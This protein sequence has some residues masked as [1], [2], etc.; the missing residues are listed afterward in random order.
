MKVFKGTGIVGNP[1][2]FSVDPNTLLADFLA[3][4]AAFSGGIF[5]AAG[6]VNRD[7]QEH[8]RTPR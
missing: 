4:D 2:S 6:D 5:V 1:L 8:T 3:Y 7:H